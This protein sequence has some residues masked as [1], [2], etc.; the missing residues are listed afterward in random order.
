[1]GEL[2]SVSSF[3]QDEIDY[4]SGVVDSILSDHSRE[5][6]FIAVSGQTTFTVSGF[7][8][9]PLNSIPDLLVFKNGIK[10]KQRL[11][12]SVSAWDFQKNSSQQIQFDYAIPEGTAIC[13]REERTGGSGGGGGSVD[14]ENIIV[15]IQPSVVGGQSVGTDIKAWRSLFLKDKANSDIYE[16]E[17]VSGVL[18]A[19]L[20]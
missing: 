15:D 8:F 12:G 7:E 6:Y 13:I 2:V 11:N 20:V 14:L 16:V 3:L 1:M 10:L 18:Q 17:I 19:T 5:E 9:S 4:V